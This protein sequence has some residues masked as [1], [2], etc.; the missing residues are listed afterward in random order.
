[1]SDRGQ[2]GA[3]TLLKEVK[4]WFE[5]YY[6]GAK[7]TGSWPRTWLNTGI[8]APHVE[9]DAEAERLRAEKRKE[10]ADEIEDIAKGFQPDAM[11][12]SDAALESYTGKTQRLF[13]LASNIRLEA[14][15]AT[16]ADAQGRGEAT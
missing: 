14:D 15:S 6:P 5:D 8:V 10:W 9:R 12:H 16:G 13:I 2:T 11:D 7:E 3:G 1:M 4:E